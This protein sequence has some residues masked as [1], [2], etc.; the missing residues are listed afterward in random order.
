MN[1]TELNA[2]EK[3]A[4]AAFSKQ[5]RGFDEYD[6]RNSIIQYKR[7]RVRT[8]V[9]SFLTPGSNILELNSGT[10]EDA[11]WFAKLGHHVHAT[12]VSMGMQ[13]VM[14]QKLAG[15]PVANQI[16]YELC[17]F[18]RLDQ[19]KNRG[20]YDII[21]SN[22][23]GLNCTGNL[24]K[25]LQSLTPLLKP[26]GVVTMVILPEFCLWETLL[27]FKGKF[28][29]ATRRF[30]SRKGVTAHIEGEYFTCWYYNPA[31]VVEHTK[32]EFEIM[33]VEGL[34]TLVPPSYLEDFPKKYPRIFNFLKK[35]EEKLKFRWPWKNIG[36]YYI[37]SL[38]K[39][40]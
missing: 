17:S 28:K 15:H 29:T 36:D 19:L 38:R 5:A 13:E 1:S 18:T 39:R 12:D 20:P 34:C 40:L 30:F 2:E 6:S 31:Y 14:V 16:S 23:A 22:S 32:K 9:Q 11:I 24:H 37:I 21:F 26:G 8:H 35:K 3:Q 10:G 27:V 25:V 4:A 33:Q 7:Q